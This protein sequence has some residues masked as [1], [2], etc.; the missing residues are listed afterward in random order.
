MQVKGNRPEIWLIWKKYIVREIF[1]MLHDVPIP[2]FYNDFSITQQTIVPNNWIIFIVSRPPLIIS[3][4]QIFPLD[5]VVNLAGNL[6][7]G[8]RY[9]QI[10]NIPGKGIHRASFLASPVSTPANYAK[11]F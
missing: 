2:K 6:E 8:G 1:I 4:N 5:S 10:T 11:A 7:R 3:T 9:N